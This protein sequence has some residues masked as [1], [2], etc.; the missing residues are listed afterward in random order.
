[1][2]VFAENDRAFLPAAI[3]AYS[4]TSSVSGTLFPADGFADNVNFPLENNVE[5][6]A[7]EPSDFINRRTFLKRL[8][9]VYVAM[10]LSQQKRT[11]I[12]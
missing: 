11:I 10:I 12:I 3:I 6:A 2:S 4:E 7:A 9:S 5:L 1:M 8:L